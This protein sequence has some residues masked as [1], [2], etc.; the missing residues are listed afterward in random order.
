MQELSAKNGFLAITCMGMSNALISTFIISV[1]IILCDLFEVL[2][3]SVLYL[4]CFT[5]ILILIQK[6]LAYL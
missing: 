6:T 2:M 4:L 5:N 1:P 3:T